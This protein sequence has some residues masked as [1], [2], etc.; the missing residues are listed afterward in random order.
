MSLWLLNTR[1]RAAVPNPLSG[2]GGDAE[3]GFS[4]GSEDPYVTTVMSVDWLHIGSL[5][6][7]GI[8]LQCAYNQ[9]ETLFFRYFLN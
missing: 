5:I 6:Y 9:W 8:I 7:V 2:L 1:S 4:D 3:L